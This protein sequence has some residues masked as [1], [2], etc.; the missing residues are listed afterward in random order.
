[1]K[2]NLLIGCLMLGTGCATT[3]LGVGELEYHGLTTEPVAFKWLERTPEGGR[4]EAIARDGEQF[5]GRFTQT[6]STIERERLSRDELIPWG[7]EGWGMSQ[8]LLVTDF[9]KVYT[10]RVLARLKGSLGHELRC[11]FTLRDPDVGM[12]GGARGQCQRSD[13]EVLVAQFP[14]SAG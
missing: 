3:G 8:P 9:V 14:A 7:W 5:S 10:G 6:V 2:T 1:M 12:N 13:G 4:L 11:Q